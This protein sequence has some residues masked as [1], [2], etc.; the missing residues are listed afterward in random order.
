MRC[1]VCKCVCLCEC[2]NECVCVSH[3]YH[4]RPHH[5]TTHILIHR[6]YF[7]CYSFYNSYIFFSSPLFFFAYAVETLS[8]TCLSIQILFNQ[9]YLFLT[10]YFTFI[11][12]H[13]FRWNLYYK[14]FTA[15]YVKIFQIIVFELLSQ[16]KEAMNSIFDNFKI[17]SI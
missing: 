15:R 10:R 16:S 2:V 5:I 1:C 9:C 12:F 11:F 4:T 8:S 6:L 3:A 17:N 13:F 7:H 14:S